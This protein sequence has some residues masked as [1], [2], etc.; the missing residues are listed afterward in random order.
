M[1]KKRIKVIVPI[2]ADEDCLNKAMIDCEAVS[3]ADTQISVCGIN[4]GPQVIEQHYDDIWA[5]LP[6]LLAAE[7]AEREG[8]DGVLIYCAGDPGLRA[9]RERLNIPCA[10]PLESGVHLAYMLGRRFSVITTLPAGVNATEDLLRLYDC[11]N[12]CASIRVLG[13]TVQELA[14]QE[15]TIAATLREAESAI[16]Q[17]RADVL[18]LGCSLIR[19]VKDIIFQRWGVPVV[20]PAAIAIKLLEDMI[21]L[22]ISHSKLAYPTPQPNRRLL[23]DNN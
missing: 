16:T 11:S 3:A 6:T 20:E 7:Q 22:N 21:E 5:E 19:G 17:D 10:G 2:L 14:D 1:S 18:V 13:L 9:V 8:F 4:W 12:R 15:K 23:P